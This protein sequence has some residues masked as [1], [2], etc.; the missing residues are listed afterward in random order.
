MNQIEI[1]F[2][3]EREDDEIELTILGYAE[4]YVPANY[5]GH[6]DNWTPPEGGGSGVEDILLDGKPWSGTLTIEEE[7]RASEEI[8]HRFIDEQE[9]AYESAMEAKAEAMREDDW[10]PEPD[11]W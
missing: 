11:F 1:E 9:A 5:R 3:V 6:P 10:Y 7:Q 4:P 2:C 8:Y